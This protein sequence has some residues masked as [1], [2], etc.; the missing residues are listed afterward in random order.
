MIFQSEIRI[1]DFTR[2]KC[3]SKVPFIRIKRDRDSCDKLQ[4][5]FRKFAYI[6]EKIYLIHVEFSFDKSQILSRLC[7]VRREECFEECFQITK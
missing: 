5:V 4:N 7:Y 2:Q 1:F 6:Y 3:R